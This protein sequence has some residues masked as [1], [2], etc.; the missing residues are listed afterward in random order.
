MRRICYS[1]W[2][3][4]LLIGCLLHGTG[5]A[6]TPEG[7]IRLSGTLEIEVATQGGAIRSVS[8]PDRRL[9][10]LS[11]GLETAQMP[12]NNQPGAPFR[13]H[14]LC[15]GRWGAPT[16]GEM[17][18]GVPH[19]GDHNNRQWQVK[20]HTEAFLH[21]TV[22]APLDQYYVEREIRL[23]P[24]SPVYAV[25]E[26]V[27]HTGTV[28]RLSNV[29]QHPTLG[30][31]FLNP[32][33][34][35]FS[36]AG[37]GFLQKLSYPDPEAYAYRWPEG[38]RDSSRQPLDLTRSAGDLNYVTTHTF[39]EG[40]SQGWVVAYDPR[41]RLLYG[42]LWETA[43]Y[44]WLHVWHYSQDGQPV[45]KG[46]EFGT[47]GIGRPYQDL[48]THDTRFR[49]QASFLY[50][51]AGETLERRY[52][53][54]LIPLETDIE[55]ITSVRWVDQTLILQTKNGTTYELLVFDE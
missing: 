11:W 46:L 5:L 22:A 10:P 12:A 45:A 3:R 28:G 43:D 13:G 6:Q 17:G 50:H 35:I 33:T 53:G 52:L 44:P 38:I 7:V 30:P 40:M 2:L 27:T 41:S 32:D 23:S 16:A 21:A 42:Y 14:F 19:N 55:G 8:L 18:A 26:R 37:P 9:N 34:R 48:L 15:L 39:D 49:G 24:H 29:V 1:C 54:F 4:G 51:D 47:A 25:T 36:N 31:P 20:A